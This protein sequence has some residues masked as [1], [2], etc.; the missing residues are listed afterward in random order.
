MATGNEEL[1]QFKTQINLCEYA[2][3]HGF[4][5]DRKQSSKSGAVMRHPSG[6]KIA[7]AKKSNGHWTYINVHESDKGSIIDFAAARLS[8]SI[9]QVRKELR[10]WI[11]GGG[12]R[13]VQPV[14][15]QSFDLKPV[16][17]DLLNVTCMWSKARAL[18]SMDQYLRSRGIPESILAEPIFADRIRIDARGNT[19][20]PHWNEVGQLCGFEIK[21]KGFTGFS[22]GG[23]K[24]LW[25]SRPHATDM[26]MVVSESAI[27]ALSIAAIFGSEGK[28]F[29][30]IAGN[31]APHQ[32]ELL[33]AAA[34][35]MP[36]DSVVWLC[37]DHDES[38]QKM[39]AEIRDS[40][41]QSHMSPNQIIER[42]PEQ[43]DRDWN[44]VLQKYPSAAPDLLA[45]TSGDSLRSKSPSL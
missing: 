18:N 15:E 8:L 28:R 20:F 21:N 43:Q 38:G 9:G 34:N 7:I 23:E 3:S 10:Q 45:N 1:N 36:Q 17:R 26:T 2:A 44:D 25:C 12:L 37:L 32:I 13:R 29:F 30:S 33:V 42:F 5:L 4:V 27:D 11:G 14:P 35:K 40:F 16:K 19:I 22:P 31:C 41:L 6:E 39:A 24:G